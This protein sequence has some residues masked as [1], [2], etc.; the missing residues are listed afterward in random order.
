MFTLQNSQNVLWSTQD[1]LAKRL[2]ILA[3]AGGLLFV[4]AQLAVP[5]HPVPLTFQSSMVILLA[6]ALGSSL[7]TQAISAYLIA[8]FCGLP[9][10]AEFMGGPGMF[11]DPATGYLFGFL[12]AALISGYLAQKGW[13]RHFISSYA[14]ALIGVSTIF[15]CGYLWL[16]F[17][18]GF[19]HAFTLGV[20]PFLLTEPL[21]LVVVALLVPRFWK[22]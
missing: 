2:S 16:S 21:K 22:V 13:G 3:I 8:G 18:I 6:M 14:A 17:F 5:M 10:F 9:V 4:A 12:P 7:G 15:A 1:K 19:H 11:I 20:A